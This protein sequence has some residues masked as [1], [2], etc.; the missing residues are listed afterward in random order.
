VVMFLPG[1]A[2]FSGA[3]ENLP[4]LIEEGMAKRVLLATPTTLI[5]LLQTVH[6]GWKQERLAEN[7]EKISE[8]GRLLHERI[9]T[10]VEHWERLGAALGKATD[11]FN[12]AASSFEGRVLPAARRLE[13]LGAASKKALPELA[14]L[15]AHPRAVMI[16]ELGRRRV[17]AAMGGE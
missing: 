6:Y 1:E 7:A 10:L 15:D 17:P 16:D 8:Q 14:T 3:L 5:A 12:A 11:H 2:I 9:C 13:E 4:G